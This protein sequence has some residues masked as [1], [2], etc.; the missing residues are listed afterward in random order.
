MR[1]PK[2]LEAAWDSVVPIMEILF[3][4]SREGDVGFGNKEWMLCYT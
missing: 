4:R 3:H 1:Q 2:T